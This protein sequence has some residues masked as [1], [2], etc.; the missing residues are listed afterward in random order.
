MKL[1]ES[2]FFLAEVWHKFVL[3]LYQDTIS[4]ASMSSL[5][6]TSTAFDQDNVDAGKTSRNEQV[7]TTRGTGSTR[8]L[9]EHA[10]THEI[11]W[12]SKRFKERIKEG[13][14][15]LQQHQTVDPHTRHTHQIARGLSGYPS[16]NFQLQILIFLTTLIKNFLFLLILPILWEKLS[17][18]K[19]TLK[20]PKKKKNTKNLNIELCNQHRVS[21]SLKR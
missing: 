13:K 10:S 1:F 14:L 12:D 3:F 21:G 15:V 8:F 11:E 16:T 19:Y 4:V 6:S 7:R 2:S 9:W 20:S 5:S 18:P 17:S